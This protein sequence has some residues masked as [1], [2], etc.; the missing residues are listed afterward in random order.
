MKNS[1]KPWPGIEPDPSRDKLDHRVRSASGVVLILTCS[2][3]GPS[4][5]G[6]ASENLQVFICGQTFTFLVFF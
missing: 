4:L 5:T 6:L 1:T 3:F 2:R